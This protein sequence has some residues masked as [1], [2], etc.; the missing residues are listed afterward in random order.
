MAAVGED[1]V[2][3]LDLVPL[4]PAYRARF[5]DGTTLDVHTDVEAMAAEI[6]R[7][8][9]QRDADGYRDFVDFAQRLY[10]LEMPHF[11]DRNIDSGG[12]LVRPALVRLAAMGGFRRLAPKIGQFFADPRPQRVFNFQSMYAG[13]SPY[14]ALALYAVIS[15]MDC[16][17]GVWFPRGGMHALPQALAGAAEKSG[18]VLRYGTTVTRVALTGRRATGVALAD[19]E[20]V[21]ADVVIVNADLPTAYRE[22]LP[23]EL[24]PRR[25]AR[26]AYSPSCMVLHVGSSKAWPDAAHHTISFGTEWREVFRDLIDR[27]TFMGDPSLLVTNPTATDPTLAPDGMQ[28]YYVLAPVPHLGAGIDW[29]VEG[30]RYRDEIVRTLEARGWAGFD[31]AI[32]VEHVVTPADWAAQ[33]IA[34]GAPFSLAHS[35]RQTGPFRPPNLARGL[36]NVVFAGCGTHPGVGVPMV[37]VSGRLAAERVTGPAGSTR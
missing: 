5:A 25:L 22:L 26:M 4:D 16:V 1:L 28:A 21:A 31:A 7:V 33:G 3:W 23:A 34:M 29:A 36:D 37:L 6:R 11:I 32:Q 12:D 35:F 9:G 15:Y 30:P 17:N 20:H 18:V 10:D 27:Q 19:G 8:C 2:D 14:D 24:A 13:L